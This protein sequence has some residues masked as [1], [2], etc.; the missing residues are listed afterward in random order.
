MTNNNKNNRHMAAL[1]SSET[2]TPI[3]ELWLGLG[4]GAAP[5]CSMEEMHCTLVH[6]QWSDSGG[7]VAGRE[8]D[9]NVA[10]LSPVLN[11][12]IQVLEDQEHQLL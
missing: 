11:A 2:E 1:Q 8:S 5:S 7:A 9:G 12:Q 10:F 4:S 3:E 6:L